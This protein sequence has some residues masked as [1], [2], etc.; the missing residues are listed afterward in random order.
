MRN[1]D[2]ISSN[3][4]P[5]NNFPVVFSSKPHKKIQTEKLKKNTENLNGKKARL[6]SCQHLYLKTFSSLG[7]VQILHF[8]DVILGK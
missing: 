6:H 4:V 3:F 8:L 7:A 1:R 2:V 5:A